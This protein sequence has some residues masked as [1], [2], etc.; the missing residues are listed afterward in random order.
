MYN[1]NM[2]NDIFPND[3]STDL[4]KVRLLIADSEQ[5]DYDQDGRLRYL[6]SD[7]DIEAYLALANGKV[8]AAAAAALYGIAANEALI[9]KVIKT[10]DLQTDG[11][12]LATE[13]RLLSRDMNNRQIAE[14]EKAAQADAFIYMPMRYPYNNPDW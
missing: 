9:S 6:L 1:R 8:F 2:A 13:L 7:E 14:D 3:P 12:K 5:K 10:E 11:A 4:G